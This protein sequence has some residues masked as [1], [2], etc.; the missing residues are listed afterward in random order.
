MKRIATTSTLLG[1][2]AALATLALGGA[3]A[4]QAVT[5]EAVTFTAADGV[6]IY[7]DLYRG[8][9]GESGALIL[10]FHQ[11]GGDARGEYGPLVP[12]LL[13]QGYSALAIDQRRGGDR[14]GGPNRTVD[15]LAGRDFSYCD[16]FADLE[17]ALDYARG[18][19]FGPIVAWGSSYSASLVFRLA[20][21]RPG[22]LVGILAFSPASGEAMAGCEPE[23][24]G[25]RIAVPALVLRP[26][27]EM[28]IERVR[29]QLAVFRDQG[30][31]TYVATHGVHGSSMLNPERV[32]GDVERNW[33]VVLAFLGS[34][35]PSE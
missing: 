6:T 35:L 28:E 14:L 16:A 33:E 13:E 26:S 20:A 17:A 30:H 34:I 3:A 1:A 22:Q 29:D 23:R 7:G 4:Q 2:T 24:F 10:L 32:E 11:G 12:R 31:R 5:S 25:E 8:G 15:A 18:A 9:E 27:S 19:G 21:E